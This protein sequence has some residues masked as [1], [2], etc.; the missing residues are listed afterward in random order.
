MSVPFT[1]PFALKSC[2]QNLM[3]DMIH[4][5]LTKTDYL[6]LVLKDPEITFFYH[7]RPMLYTITYQGKTYMVFLVEEE[8]N[9]DRYLVVEYIAPIYALL[10]GGYITLRNFVTHPNHTVHEVLLEYPAN[11]EPRILLGE[12]YANNLTI[13]DAYLPTPDATWQRKI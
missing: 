4:T 8:I 7:D 1:H 12:Q 5:M 6:K 9:I 3:D 10:N 11:A 13:P 2:C